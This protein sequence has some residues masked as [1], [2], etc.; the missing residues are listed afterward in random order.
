MA[1][2]TN[3]AL[4]GLLALA[5]GCG[6]AFNL[7]LAVPVVAQTTATS[8]RLL[9][10]LGNRITSSL[11]GSNRGIHA[12]LIDPGT[13]LPLVYATDTKGA[14]VVDSNTT[15]TTEATDSQLSGGVGATG[16]ASVAAGAAGSLS[17]KLRF[18]TGL[19]VG[20]DDPDV[21]GTFGVGTRATAFGANPTAV[22]AADRSVWR[23]NRHGVPF[24]QLGHPNVVP[25]STRYTAAQ[26][27]TALVS[28]SAGSKIVV[29][30]AGLVCD[31][32]NTVDVGFR[33]GFGA[34]TTPTTT[35]VLVS[36]GGVAPGSGYERGSAVGKAGADGEDVRLTMEVP[37]TGSCDALLDYYTIES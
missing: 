9:D 18:L 4:L 7:W 36:H 29:L 26:T 1:T 34:T 28:V 25:F 32:A 3:R 30:S 5:A 20:H 31:H 10:G 15:R 12:L 13:D 33:I 14:G 37:T 21:A 35:G 6:F 17:A 27:D 23:A 16:D 19:L 11:E 2:R 24:V 22:A 8:L